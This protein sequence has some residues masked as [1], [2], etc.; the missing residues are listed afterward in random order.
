MALEETTGGT[1][2]LRHHLHRMAVQRY[3]AFQKRRFHL[4]K[5]APTQAGDASTIAIPTRFLLACAA[6]QSRIWPLSPTACLFVVSWLALCKYFH[7]AE[8]QIIAYSFAVWVCD[9]P[10]NASMCLP[11]IIRALLC[12]AAL[13]SLILL[14]LFLCFVSHLH[15]GVQRLF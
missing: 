1:Q 15:P 2:V 4:P 3:P 8:P 5:Q 6:A 12:S 11:A 7:P 10:A 13:S 14:L 9:E